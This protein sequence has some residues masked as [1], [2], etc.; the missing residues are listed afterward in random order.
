MLSTILQVAKPDIRR[1][2][3]H[4]YKTVP[5]LELESLLET[6]TDCPATQKVANNSRCPA[7]ACFLFLLVKFQKSTTMLTLYCL[8]C[9][10]TVVKAEFE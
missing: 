5:H 10:D 1:R 4:R 6:E 2:L 7:W 3:T 9:L 8:C